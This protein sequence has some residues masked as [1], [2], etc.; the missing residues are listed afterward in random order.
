VN[1]RENEEMLRERIAKKH[2]INKDVDNDLKVQIYSKYDIFI[3]NKMVIY[4]DYS[5]NAVSIRNADKGFLITVYKNI[6]GT[7]M[8]CNTY[9]VDGVESAYAVIKNEIGGYYI[10]IDNVIEKA[11]N[12]TKFNVHING[13]ILSIELNGYRENIFDFSLVKSNKEIFDNY[14]YRK[15]V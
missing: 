7:L 2:L 4:T 15:I 12:L 14:E 8:T 13:K 11:F 1:Y 6:L 10:E 9:M 5:S 3:R